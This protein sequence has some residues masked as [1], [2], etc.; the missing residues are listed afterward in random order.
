[1]NEEMVQDQETTKG[2]RSGTQRR[3]AAVERR[4][5]IELDWAASIGKYR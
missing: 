5:L 3:L 1:M 2:Q 4:P